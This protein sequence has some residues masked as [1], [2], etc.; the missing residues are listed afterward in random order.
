M[1][2]IAGYLIVRRPFFD[3]IYFE[4]PLLQPINNIFYN[5][6]YR[7]EWM[8]IDN[9]Y[10]SKLLSPYLTRSYEELLT[11]NSDFSFINSTH[12]LDLIN[13]FINFN[14]EIKQKNEIIVISAQA[15]DGVKGV[16]LMDENTIEWL[17]YD[18]VLWGGWSLIRHGLFENRQITLLDKKKLN[19]YG[20]F[21]DIENIKLFLDAYIFLSELNL[22]DPLIDINLVGEIKIGRLKI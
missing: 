13:A 6:L 3:Q 18:F 17:G 15:L 14:D 9:Y 11:S 2:S 21:D 8:D 20:L 5:G 22:V 4:G 7:S 12:N 19:K 16:A 10:Y 1:N